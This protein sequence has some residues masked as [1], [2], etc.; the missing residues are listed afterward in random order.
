MS[1]VRLLDDLPA[2][3]DR[4]DWIDSILKGDCVAALEKLLE[5]EPER[6]RLLFDDDPPADLQFSGPRTDDALPGLSRSDHQAREQDR[7]R[8]ASFHGLRRS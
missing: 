1:A 5:T 3:S 7:A 4:T 8:A 2:S 6:E